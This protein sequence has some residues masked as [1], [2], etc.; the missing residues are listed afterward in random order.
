[1]L[2][3]ILMF[4]L[5]I[6]ASLVFANT[7]QITPTIAE[8]QAG[9]SIGAGPVQ[10]IEKGASLMLKLLAGATFAGI[11]AAVFS[12]ARKF[13]KTWMRNSRT[14]RWQAGPNAQFKQTTPAGPKLTHNDLMLL[15][16]SGRIPPGQLQ[17]NSR[18][19]KI[20]AQ[21]NDDDID[22]EF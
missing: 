12:E 19:G 20:R 4:V 13:Y 2:G 10:V 6:A 18:I 9:M 7:D 5:L 21:S 16:L 8:A 1:M 22:L 15:A 11:A 17:T 3:F 14:K